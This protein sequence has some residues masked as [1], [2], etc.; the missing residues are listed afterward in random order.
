V[1]YYY[2]QKLKQEMRPTNIIKLE[3]VMMPWYVL[4]PK[5]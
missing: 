1:N 4:P 3:I 2:A 5:N